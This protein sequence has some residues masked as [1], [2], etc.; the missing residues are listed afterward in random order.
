MRNNKTLVSLV[1]KKMNISLKIV[2]GIRYVVIFQSIY[3]SSSSFYIYIK[4]ETPCI[5]SKLVSWIITYE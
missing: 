2:R 1:N 5:F 4:R 3:I